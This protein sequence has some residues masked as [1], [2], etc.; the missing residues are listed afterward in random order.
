MRE[1]QSAT[2]AAYRRRFYPHKIRKN[3]VK[4]VKKSIFYYAIQLWLQMVAN[5][6]K[7]YEEGNADL[8]LS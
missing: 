7:W 1:G 6:C 3:W 5:G 8:I 4:T 2:F